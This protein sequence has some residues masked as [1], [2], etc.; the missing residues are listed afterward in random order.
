MDR[1]N[2]DQPHAVSDAQRAF[3]A[4]VVGSYLPPPEWFTE[5]G[6]PAAW[7]NFAEALFAGIASDISLIPRDGVDPAAAWDHATMILGS[8]QP[9]HEHKISGV[10]WLLW[11]W[12]SAGTYLRY[13]RP[14]TL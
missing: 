6:V 1:S 3:P 4:R 11:H 12:F 5:D 14:V 10:A 9:K 13:G 8:Y 7:G 2:F